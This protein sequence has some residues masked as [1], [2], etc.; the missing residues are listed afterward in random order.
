MQPFGKAQPI[1]RREDQRFLTGAGRYLDDIAPKDALHA[2]FL[3]SPH[4][5]A[6]ISALDASEA[7]ALPGVHLVLTHEDLRAAGMI[8]DIEATILTNRDGSPAAAPARQILAEGIVRHVG[9]PIACIVA[10]SPEIAQAAA[11]LV[12]VDYEELAPHLALAPGG[13]QIHPEAPDNIALDWE[14]GD[15]AAT[16]AAFGRAAH[17]VALELADNRVFPT[18]LEPRGCFADWPEGGRLH[19]A[20]TGQGVWDMKSR[21]ARA[22]ALG[23]EDLR[24]STPD[25][26]GA[27]GM[28]A[29]PYPEYFVLPEAARRLG[30]PVR[31]MSGR[32]EAMISD[33]SGR[34]LISRAEMAFDEDLRILGYRVRT[35]F[36]LGAWNS[37]FGQ[38]IQTRLFFTVMQG[39]Y[40]MGAMH[41]AAQG[42]YTNTPP[43]DAYRGAGRPEAIYVLER[44]M[45][46]AARQLGADPWELRRR[47]FIPPEA[48]PHESLAGETIDVGDFARVLA[49]AREE[50]DIAGFPARRAESRARGRLR[51]LGLSYYL[52]A[53]L[54]APAEDARIEFRSDGGVDLLV[55]TQSA[56][57]GHETAFAGFLSDHTGI[58]LEKINVIQGDSDRIP[59]GGGTGGSRSATTQNNATLATVRKMI[60]AFAAFIAERE[61]VPPEDVRFDDER[62]R[63]AGSNFSPT[64]LEAAELARAAGRDDLLHHHARASL[65]GRSY[66]NGA[67]VAELEL[68]PETGAAQVVRYTVVDDLGRLLN[69]LLVEG[70]IH[71]GVAQG[72]GQA[73]MEHVVFDEDGQLLS[74]SLMDYAL[75]RAEDVPEI[76][77][78][79]EPVLSTANEMGMKG[80]G[81]AGTVGALAAVANAMA[82]A[83]APLGI[84]APD[85]PFTPLRVWAHLNEAG[86]R[87]SPA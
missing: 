38:A 21:L 63:I 17:V 87:S 61:G 44:M 48:F 50:A 79:S 6:R 55:G 57:Q 9:E 19:L 4:A 27:F 60:P 2:A 65:P 86:A 15:A 51:G 64:L 47:N 67:H 41:L 83:L 78:V 35:R 54:G 73:M 56:G 69:P 28:K 37:A 53:I 85:M 45:D 71:G 30:R 66:P 77:F 49:R 26:G 5:H 43:V 82:D 40:R 18:S 16:E 24:V 34:D 20:F 1:R 74:A 33:T 25:V 32:M 23:P 12:W 42:I 36:N 68:D 58:P 13:P 29:M 3:R 10:D 7:R 14:A 62:F 80:C 52:E 22:F 31:W 39:A 81:E 46:H 70:Q 84:E 11:E 72:I 59:S 76:G 75:P 8:T